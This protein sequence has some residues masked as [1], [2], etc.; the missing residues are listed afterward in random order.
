[1]PEDGYALRR[2]NDLMMDKEWLETVDRIRDF[3]GQNHERASYFL[4]LLLG[5]SIQGQIKV[6]DAAKMALVMVDLLPEGWMV[7]PS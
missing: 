5:A 4:G 7:F 3:V 6:E 1:M 2:W